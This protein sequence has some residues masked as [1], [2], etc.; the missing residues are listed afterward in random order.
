MTT[1]NL[2]PLRKTGRCCTGAEADGGVLYHAVEATQ[3][4]GWGKAICGTQPGVRGNGW[5]WDPG[6]AVTC[7]ACLKRLTRQ[8]A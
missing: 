8:K 2:I 5:S 1:L 4:Q 6:E 3:R 7:P